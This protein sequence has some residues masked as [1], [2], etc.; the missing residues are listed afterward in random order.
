MASL[1]SLHAENVTN[2][3]SSPLVTYTP[4][5]DIWFGHYGIL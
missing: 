5:F 4:H 3:L 2:E 1:D